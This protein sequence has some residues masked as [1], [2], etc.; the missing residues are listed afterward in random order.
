MKV[1]KDFVEED[2]D[3]ELPPPP[4]FE[5]LA[6]ETVSKQ[7]PTRQVSSETRITEM[8]IIREPGVPLGMSIAG[9]IGSAPCGKYE[10][11]VGSSVLKFW[12]LQYS[13]SK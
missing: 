10:V 4:S 1:D 12:K 7:P 2:I 5:E 3:K 11:S 9:G 6:M 8:H 13:I